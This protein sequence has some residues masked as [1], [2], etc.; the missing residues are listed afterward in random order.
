VFFCLLC[1]SLHFVLHTVLCLF[2][3]FRFSSTITVIYTLAAESWKCL[4]L[5]FAASII[6]GLI[7]SDLIS[8]SFSFSS[9]SGLDLMA[10]I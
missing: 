3:V 10:V 6:L 1:C 5:I 2:V 7:L 9:V 4:A 8:S